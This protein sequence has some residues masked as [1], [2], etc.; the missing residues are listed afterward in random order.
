M[1]RPGSAGPRPALAPSAD[2]HGYSLYE[3][4]IDTSLIQSWQAQLVKP[5][6]LLWEGWT[7]LTSPSKRDRFA[8]ETQQVLHEFQATV[9]DP[10]S[11]F[12][13]GT[14]HSTPSA[15]TAASTA[16]A[17]QRPPR[18]LGGRPLGGHRASVAAVG[19][20]P[21]VAADS[22]A[23]GSPSMTMST[24]SVSSMGSDGD[25]GASTGSGSRQ[26]RSAVVAKLSD[27]GPPIAP[28]GRRFPNWHRIQRYD[29]ESLMAQL[30]SMWEQLDERETQLQYVWDIYNRDVF[31]LRETIFRSRNG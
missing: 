29:H 6:Q 14:D 4:K 17:A 3:G 19:E 26:R 22:S 2:S 16:S 25:G 28:S 11:I 31:R 18:A 21:A 15:P 24:T 7:A 23:P 10:L 30:K 5:D 9:D 20:L 13:E 1:D 27:S 12:S 8:R